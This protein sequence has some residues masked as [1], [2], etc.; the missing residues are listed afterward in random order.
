[1]LKPWEYLFKTH[2][3]A[4]G[5]DYYENGAVISLKRT[6]TGYKATVEGGY[7]Y[8]VEVE[9]CDNEVVEMFCDCPYAEDGNYCKHMAAVLYEIEE[10]SAQTAREVREETSDIKTELENVIKNIDETEVRNMLLELAL[11]D[12]SLQNHIFIKYADNISSIQMRRLKQ[13]VEVIAWKYSDRSGYIDYY[14]AMDYINALETFL[15]ENV[16]NLIDKNLIMPAFELTNEVFHTVGNQ[17]I[18][19]SDGGTT[20]IADRCYEYWKHILVQATDEQRKQMFQWFK[21]HPKDYVIDFMEDY[22]SDFLMDEFHDETM[23]REKMQMLDELIEH[24]GDKSDCGGWYSSYYGYEN[25][26]LKRLQ[27]M[28]ELNYS[29]SEINEYR[30]KFRHFSAIRELEVREYLNK[31]EYNKAIETLEES[32]KLDREYARLVSKYSEQLI[33]IYQKT[34]QKEEYKKELIYQIFFCKQDNLENIKLL[35]AE[36]DEEEWNTYQ[37]QIVNSNSCIGIKLS[38]LEF[39]ELYERLLETIVESGSIYTLDQYEKILKKKFPDIIRDTYVNYIRK[40]AERVCYRKAYKGLMTYM[41]K[42]VKYPGGKGLA[43]QIAKEWKVIYRRRT[44]MMDE[45]RKAGF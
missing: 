44:A 34:G 2:I 22:I 16:Q 25:N 3:L 17:D 13:E 10:K 40:Q 19:D 42:L 23:L 39:E 31:E 24:A 41:K 43:D 27:I 26:I 7:N 28:K 1:M 36:C 38:F 18:D 14:H 32:K 29:E 15:D 9:I 12:N 45:L 21:R 6:E 11:K 20:W 33:H 37:E 30:T 5:Q 35:K 4:R 8:E